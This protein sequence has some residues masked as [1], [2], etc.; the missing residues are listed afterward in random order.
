MKK[1][2]K[3]DILGEEQS[4]LPVNEGGS[5]LR[6]TEGCIMLTRCLH[7]P[8]WLSER[9]LRVEEGVLLS[10]TD[11]KRRRAADFVLQG[12]TPSCQQARVH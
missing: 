4:D 10:A 2:E 3:D 8:W 11:S 7:S 5:K 1:K 12:T 6:Q 9:K